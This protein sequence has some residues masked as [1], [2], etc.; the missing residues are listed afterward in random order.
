MLRYVDGGKRFLPG[1]WPTEPLPFFE[2]GGSVTVYDRAA[3]PD[4][5]LPA[6]AGVA[7]R[8]LISDCARS[9]P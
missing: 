3:R 9:V 4:A 5:G 2:R 8:G 1:D 7:R 6:V